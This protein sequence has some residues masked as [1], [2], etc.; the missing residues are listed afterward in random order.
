MVGAAVYA[1]PVISTE[2]PTGQEVRRSAA[3]R[4][5]A[6]SAAV[7]ITLGILSG[8]GL[9]EAA[10]K[11]V[12]EAAAQA[13]A[14]ASKAAEALDPWDLDPGTCYQNDDTASTEVASVKSIPCTDPHNSQVVDVVT[15]PAGTSWVEVKTKKADEDCGKIF[16]K[17]LV[18]EAKKSLEKQDRVYQGGYIYP[19]VTSWKSGETNEIACIVES[20]KPIT[21]SLVK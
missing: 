13:D 11:A 3:G 19:D 9:K 18:A 1:A 2:T 14:V 12:D 16:D 21:K 17:K 15:Y 6:V 7:L 20:T 4:I 8:C 10:D 5:A